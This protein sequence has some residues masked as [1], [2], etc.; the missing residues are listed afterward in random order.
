MSADR[1]KPGGLPAGGSPRADIDAFLSAATPLAAARGRGRLIFAL[2]ATMSRQPSWDLAMAVQARMFAT[3]AA[4][5]GLDAQLV[6]YRGFGECRASRFMSGGRELAA[7]MTRIRVAGGRT[8]IAKV[9]RHAL[10]EAKAAPIAALVFVGDA[11]EESAD[12]LC[13]LAGRLGLLGVKAF[14]FQEGEDRLAARLFRRIALMT[15]GAYATFDAGAAER[16]AALLSAAAAYAAGGR[17]ALEI[18]ARRE[19]RAGLLLGQMK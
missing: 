10:D 5:G 1:E 15:G 16:L 6:F 17:G 14:M 12:E 8:Q 9:L 3:A 7:A 11:M 13:D 4:H 18:E 2:D 19:A